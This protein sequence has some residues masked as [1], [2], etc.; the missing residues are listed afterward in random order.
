MLQ[1]NFKSVAGIRKILILSGDTGGNVGDRAILWSM[2]HAFRGIN[3]SLEITIV[4][5][6]PDRDESFFKASTI[7]KGISG[8]PALLKAAN[9][10]DLILCGGGGRFPD[11]DS[12][13]KMPYWALRI[14]MVRIFSKKIIGYSLG[15]GPLK[16][17]TS[18]WFAR[19]AFACMDDIS[20]RD[21]LAKK[22]AKNLTTK[23]IHVVPDPALLL[24]QAPHEE[25]VTIL[26]TNRIPVNESPLI[27]VA[28]RRW[29]HQRSALIPHKYA[30]KYHLR[31]I[32]GREKCEKM[33]QLLAEVLDRLVK[34]Y[35]AYIVFLPTYN[36]SHEA[37]YE[38][39]SQVMTKMKFRRS[40]LLQ[41]ND[42]LL[43]KAIAGCLTVMLGGRMHP[44]ILSAG[45]G[46]N[47]V[48]LSYNQKFFGFFELLGLKRKVLSVE[49]FVHHKQVDTL[50]N[51]L[52]EAIQIDFHP[53][54]KAAAISQQIHRF[55][56]HILSIPLKN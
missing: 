25:A 41:I 51:L 23:P 21:N 45:A 1:T 15:V 44:T 42:P 5:G 28:A 43:Y 39:C 7:R 2:C 32:P 31:K 22:T 40:S 14:A 30:V 52:C 19:L 27:G 34:R 17:P 4:S 47:I 26:K 10:S 53:Q 46:T 16:K 29:F 3:P 36:V 54:E 48:G 50:Y 33:T 56:E 37:D 18:R 13:V 20:V 9:K 24:P 38:F 35:Q 11:D 8:I 55:N 6:C 12:L 49:N